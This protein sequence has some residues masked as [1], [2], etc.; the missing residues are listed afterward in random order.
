MAK[1]PHSVFKTIEKHLLTGIG[2]MIPVVIGAS[3]C[4]GIALAIGGADMTRDPSIGGPVLECLYNAGSYGLALFIPICGAYISWSIAD[5][6]GIAPAL[7]GSYM[8]YQANAGFIGA[9]VVGF[10]AGYLVELLKK[11][12]FPAVLEQVKTLMF[13]PFVATLVVAL[14]VNFVI[15]PP[16]GAAMTALENWVMGMTAG[17]KLILGAVLGAMIGFDYGGPVNK[18]A[19]AVAVSFMTAG[20]F[21]LCGA[22]APAMTVPGL[23]ICIAALVCPRKFTAEERGNAP[24]TGIVALSTIS[25]VAIPYA[26]SDPLR[27]ML[28]SSIGGGVSGAIAMMF[29]VEVRMS[30]GGLF[31]LPVTVNIPMYLV[32]MFAGSAVCALI[33][34]LLKKDVPEGS[35]QD[36]D[37][38]MLIDPELLD[39][40]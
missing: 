40:V 18:T 11:I 4:F 34:I 3:F 5:R 25:E 31:V 20:T 9:I 19:V 1:S 35:A 8:A 27:V 32:A 17:N 15:A 33:L 39:F 21:T 6:A 16:V 29:D 28:A 23:G 2:Y 12:K 7:I 38:D 13:L 22:I 14:F 10:F 24:S 26:A 36:T 30:L 37:D